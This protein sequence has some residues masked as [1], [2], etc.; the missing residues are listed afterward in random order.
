MPVVHRPPAGQEL[1]VNAVAGR[2]VASPR[3][4]LANEVNSTDVPLVVSIRRLP[5]VLGVGCAVVGELQTLPRTMLE[6]LVQQALVCTVEALAS[7][8]HGLQCPIFPHAGRD[9]HD[10]AVEGIRPANVWC[11]CKGSLNVEQ[12]VQGSECDDVGIEVDDFAELHL[13]PQGDFGKGEGEVRPAH[14]VEV[15][16][17]RGSYALDGDDVV[18]ERLE[19]GDGVGGKR[20]EGDEDRQLLGGASIAQRVGKNGGS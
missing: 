2:A 5:L 15:S 9:D 10:T 11:R 3:L 13:P 8:G 16:G 4:L 14:E 12:L 19:P 7:S 20:V 18:V 1:A 6:V 17:A